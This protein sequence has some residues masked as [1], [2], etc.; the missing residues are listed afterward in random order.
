MTSGFSGRLEWPSPRYGHLATEK[1]PPGRCPL[2]SLHATVALMTMESRENKP[3]G[4]HHKKL[5]FS[6]QDLFA[7][8]TYFRAKG[9]SDFR[10]DAE[11]DAFRFPEDG[12][13]AFCREFADWKALR[14]RGY[15]LF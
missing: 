3:T 8:E 10:Y 2:A 1:W 12:R 14:E 13:F 15:W 4:H 7:I 9:V 5:P 11:L 6:S